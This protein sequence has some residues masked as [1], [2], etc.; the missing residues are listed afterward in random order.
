MI[1]RIFFV[2]ISTGLVGFPIFLKYIVVMRFGRVST[3]LIA[4]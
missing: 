4:Y 2:D 3:Q 1:C